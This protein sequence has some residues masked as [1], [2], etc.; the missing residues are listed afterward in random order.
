MPS[1]GK[2]NISRI[3]PRGILDSGD[4]AS[5]SYFRLHSI[6]LT[7]Y[8]GVKP[9]P[10]ITSLVESFTITEELYSPIVT[11]TANIKDSIN[12]FEAAKICGQE[13]I[14]IKISKKPSSKDAETE[15][16]LDFYVKEYTNF[17]RS[18]TTPNTQLYTLVAV[19]EFAYVS[20]LKK[21]SRSIK[22]NV[23]NNIKDIFKKDLNTEINASDKCT[24]EFAGII[25]IQSPLRA[26]EWL[27]TRA[28]TINHSPFFL[29]CNISAK[30]K[31]VQLREW[32][33]I[34]S[35][36]STKTFSY[37]QFSSTLP[38]TTA[39]YD[40]GM[41]R[42]LDLKSNIRLD[43]L[44]QASKGAFANKL[45]VI[46][47]AT[48]SY[49]TTEYKLTEDN[50][51]SLSDG[52]KSLEYKINGSTGKGKSLYDITDVSISTLQVNTA[53]STDNTVNSISKVVLD[54]IRGAKL[55]FGHMNESTQT[56]LVFGDLNL[57]PGKKITLKIPSAKKVDASENVA[58]SLDAMLSGDYIITV[59]AHMFVDGQY[60]TKLTLIKQNIGISS[61]S[62]NDNPLEL[63]LPQFVTDTLA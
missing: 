63:N 48:K 25:T 6:V 22:K 13:K 37:K 52:K 53:V 41:T 16:T 54:N 62:S 57:N 31:K 32:E 14:S 45:Q 46:D 11:F 12:F 61:S 43:K 8:E 50:K 49:Y 4:P 30:D 24:S 1:A 26:I 42:I 47:Y 60:T 15:I 17:E 5:P 2:D 23:V 3:I 9:I 33:K 7:N 34:I 10:D 38:G 36:K 44:S 28:F 21:I 58:E 19:P 51:I 29:Y 40:E 55:L 39:A 20:E 18:L 56:L 27:R 59:A 35:E